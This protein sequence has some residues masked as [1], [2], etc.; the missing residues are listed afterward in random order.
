MSEFIVDTSGMERLARALEAIPERAEVAVKRGTK[1]ALVAAKTEGMRRARE[2]Y[3]IKGMRLARQIKMTP[4][5]MKVVGRR[6]PLMEFDVRPEVPVQRARVFAR[7]KVT[8]GGSL[9]HA[10]IAR[11]PSNA[12]VGVYERVGTRSF[13][14]RQLMGVSAPQMMG[15]PQVLLAMEER[16][17]EVLEERVLH[18]AERF[19]EE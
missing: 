15:E 8:G 16:A 18:E 14:I 4:D 9:P 10:F 5:H 13:P 11:M 17:S 3:T 19:L 12:H 1:R 7:V 6:R 2:V